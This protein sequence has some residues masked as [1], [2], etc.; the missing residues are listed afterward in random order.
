MTAKSFSFSEY[1]WPCCSHLLAFSS[2]S[3][4]VI[5]SLSKFKLRKSIWSE[6]NTLSFFKFSIKADSLSPLRFTFLFNSLTSFGFSRSF[7]LLWARAALVWFRASSTEEEE[8]VWSSLILLIGGKSSSWFVLVLMGSRALGGA[9]GVFTAG[10]LCRGYVG[11]QVGTAV[12]LECLNLCSFYI[13]IINEMV[14]ANSRVLGW[15]PLGALI[16]FSWNCSYPFLE[17]F[18][19]RKWKT[20]TGAF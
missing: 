7:L 14:T 11:N 10:C 16:W 8:Y 4:S 13:I 19:V 2:F 18:R 1:L 17:S 5:V 9:L 3:I 6:L 20:G 15:S 12:E